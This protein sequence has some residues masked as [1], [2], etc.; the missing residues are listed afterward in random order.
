[1][2]VGHSGHGAS[3]IPDIEILIPTNTSTPTLTPEQAPIDARHELSMLPHPAQFLANDWT[4][5]PRAHKIHITDL[6]CV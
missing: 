5:R 1:M 6:A 4:R 3:N 2:L